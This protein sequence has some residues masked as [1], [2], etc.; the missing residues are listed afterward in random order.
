[1]SR[2]RQSLRLAGAAAK[3]N[4]LPGLLLQCLMLAF[5]SLYIAHEGTRHFLGEVAR[6]KQEAGYGFSFLSYVVAGAVLPELLR[7]VFFQ[8]GKPTRTNLWLLLTAAPLW[9]GLGMLVDLLYRLQAVWFGD[10]HDWFTLSRKVLVDQFLFS[11]FL[12]V[13]LI[14]GWFLLRDDEFRPSAFRKIFRAD[15]VFEKVFPVVVA[16]WCVWIP[17]VILVYSMPPLLQIPV[18][19]FIQ[20]FWVLLFTTMEDLTG[21]SSRRGL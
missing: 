3:A 9:G 20:V 2:F 7:V 21:R 18:A 19:V 8:S 16:A 12:A 11:P 17:G 13:P 15:F 5:F 4:F 14:V 6:V 10:G 1:M